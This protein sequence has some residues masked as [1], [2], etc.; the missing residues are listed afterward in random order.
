MFGLQLIALD[1]AGRSDALWGVA[2]ARV[3]AFAVVASLAAVA[4]PRVARGALTP[5]IAIGILDT[6]ANGAFALASTKGLLSVVAVLGSLFP[7]VTVALAH[8]HLHE[9]LAPWQR[10]GVAMALTGT[11]AIAGG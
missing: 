8:V 3:I 1:H 2:V 11:L 7:V 4:R 10:V 6:T 9:R 5:L